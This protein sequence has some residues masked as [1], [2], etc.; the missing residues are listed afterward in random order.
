VAD[1]Y[2]VSSTLYVQDGLLRD[3]LERELDLGK[4]VLFLLYGTS[5]NSLL[6][7]RF[8]I[9]L[10]G[11]RHFDL[12]RWEDPDWDRD[13]MRNFIIARPAEAISR[14]D[15]LLGG[16]DRVLCTKPWAVRCFDN[17]K[18]LLSVKAIDLVDVS[19]TASFAAE[20]DRCVAATEGGPTRTPQVVVMGMGTALMDR[21]I[22]LDGADNYRLAENIV[23]WLGGRRSQLEIADEC[24]GLI[25]EIEVGLTPL[26]RHRLS[27]VHGAASWFLGLSDK[28]RRKIEALRPDDPIEQALDL[29]DKVDVMFKDEVLTAEVGLLGTRSKT[30]SKRAWGKLVSLRNKVDHPDKLVE[31][32]SES[33]N[34][35]WREKSP[36]GLET[37]TRPYLTASTTIH[38][39]FAPDS[40]PRRAIVARADHLLLRHAQHWSEPALTKCAPV[41]RKEAVAAPGSLSG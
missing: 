38:G 8:G 15:T 37:R 20:S 14:I 7:R 40:A 12:A 13:S 22:E 32:I 3:A 9:A 29:S 27:D 11:E 17:A 16:V 30:K 28:T 33:L 21:W 1:A 36:T 31:P 41:G 34:A 19:D 25:K 2:I 4:R 5:L 6:E 39:S 18:P 24:D 10:T 26:I 23:R 35:R